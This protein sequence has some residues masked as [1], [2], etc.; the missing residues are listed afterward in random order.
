MYETIDEP[1]QVGVIFKNGQIFPRVFLWQKKKFE[2]ENVDMVHSGKIG[3]AKIY[4][5][6][7][8]NKTGAYKISFNNQTLV[9]RL[10][11][12]YAE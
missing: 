7:V 2:V 6:S 12:V 3:S 8:S 5:F 4:Y 9:W 11:Q 10:E 1:I